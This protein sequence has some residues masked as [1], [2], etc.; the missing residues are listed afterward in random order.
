MNEKN[1]T[2]LEKWGTFLRVGGGGV[3]A[4]AVEAPVQK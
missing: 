4:E 2:F 3:G 1:L